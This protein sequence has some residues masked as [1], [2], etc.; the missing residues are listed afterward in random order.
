MWCECDQPGRCILRSKIGR[1]P[2]WTCRASSIR[3][4]LNPVVQAPNADSVASP[5]MSECPGATDHFV[6]LHE[7]RKL[8]HICRHSMPPIPS[9]AT[10]I[11]ITTHK[12][13]TIPPP[14]ANPLACFVDASTASP[15]TPDLASDGLWLSGSHPWWVSRLMVLIPIPPLIPQHNTAAPPPSCSNTPC[16]KPQPAP[17]FS[18]FVPP[19]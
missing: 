11:R 2:A 18:S 14:S 19:H 1:Q 4:K 12:M 7:L 3:G 6:G 17:M 15:S 8:L 5:A 10:R 16:H 13:G 9:P